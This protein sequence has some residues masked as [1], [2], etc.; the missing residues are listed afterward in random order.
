MSTGDNHGFEDAENLLLNE[1][2]FLAEDS[3][4]GDDISEMERRRFPYYSEYGLEFCSQHVLNQ[5][6][7]ARVAKGSKVAYWSHAHDHE[8]PIKRGDRLLHEFSGPALLAV[9]CKRTEKE[10]KNGGM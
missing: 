1:G 2:F 8:L 4:L 3:A 7:V 9:G 10:F 5:W 6:G